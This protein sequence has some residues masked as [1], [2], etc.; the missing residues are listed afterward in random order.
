MVIARALAVRPQTGGIASGDQGE[1]NATAQGA[2]IQQAPNLPPHRPG[3]V[4]GGWV[5]RVV[6]AREGSGAE[7]V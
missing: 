2:V 5:G 6:V 4:A 7:L 1:A 3:L